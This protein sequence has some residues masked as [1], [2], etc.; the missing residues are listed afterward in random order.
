[1]S[2]DPW[3]LGHM[4]NWKLNVSSFKRSIITKLCR[5]VTNDKGNSPIVSHDSLT[6]KSREVTWQTKNKIC[7]LAQRLW[8]SNLAGW[9]LIMRET[10]PCHMSLWLRGHMRSRAKLKTKY[11]LF[12]KADGYQTW[13]SGNLWWG[14]GLMVRGTPYG[15]TWFS[16][17]LEM[18]GHVIN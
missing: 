8:P 10:H 2:H 9:R 6:T 11:L 5:V 17:N 13:Q 16:D 14:W 7:S 12:R 1:M 18:C 4:T 15:V 3:S